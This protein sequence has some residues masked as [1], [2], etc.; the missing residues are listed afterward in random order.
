MNPATVDLD[1]VAA[2]KQVED[3]QFARTHPQSLAMRE[4]ARK[5]MPFGVPMVWMEFSYDHPPVY[6]DSGEGTYFTDIDGHRYLDM[7]HGITVSAAGHTPE[8]VV[9][10]A[11]DRLSRGT[12]FQLPTVDSV[13]VAEELARRWGLPKWQFQLSS[14]QAITDA[15]HLAR[16]F[17]DREKILVFEGKYHGHLAELLAMEGDDGTT[18][19]EYLG[20]TDADVARTV[21]VPWNDLDRVEQA[22]SNN[23]V[24]LLIAE[25]LLS[26]SGMV[27]PS[28]EFHQQLR[29]LT[30]MHGTLLAI[31]ETQ[32]LPLA[33]GGLY[34]AWGLTADLLIVGK[35]LGG[36][37]P[38]AAV[39]MTDDLNPLIDR[40]FKAY[41]VSGEA[42]DEP[43][44]GGTLFGNAL[45]MAAARAALED[46]WVPETYARTSA[47]A[48]RMASGMEAAIRSHGR[49]WDVY[50]I[51]NRAGFRFDPRT[52]R[53]NAEAADFDL[54]A[55]RHLQRVFMVNRGVWDFGW[56]GG[57]AIS[58]QTTGDDVDFYLSVFHEFMDALLI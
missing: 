10:A 33:Y 30:R 13:Y 42:V 37:V 32:T 58:A 21:I 1:R 26:N 14:T 9:R 2:L 19:P 20:I 12:Q 40:E 31:D 44:I 16:L 53:N 35:S 49:D 45:S 15:V 47:L 51:G 6:V 11:A 52:P 23:D 34:R 39:G 18:T 57:P 29:E 7:F 4:R 8:A 22:L 55:V 41:E 36:G 17:T 27:F 48:N 43:A 54:P 28:E 56:W 38:V 50:S 24:A 5:S 25:P 46:V 3:E